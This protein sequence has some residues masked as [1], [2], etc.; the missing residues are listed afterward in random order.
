MTENLTQQHGLVREITNRGWFANP[1]GKQGYEVILLKR[2][3]NGGTRFYHS[4]K[5]GQ[6]LRIVERLLSSYIALEVDMRHARAFTVS[7]SFNTRHSGRNVTLELNVRYHV[8]DA[9][10]V[11]METVDPLGELRDKVISALNR[12]L[13]TYSERDINLA[14]IDK[15]VMNIGQVPHLGLV[16]EDLDVVKFEKDSSE[17][18]REQKYITELQDAEHSIHLARLIGSSN[19]SPLIISKLLALPTKD[20]FREIGALMEKAS[21]PALNKIFSEDYGE[22]QIKVTSPTSIH[23]GIPA[24]SL[25]TIETYI[26][27]INLLLSIDVIYI[28]LATLKLGD[29]SLVKEFLS[30]IKGLNVRKLSDMPLQFLEESKISTLQ[31]FSVHYGSPVSVDILGVGTVLET[32]RDTIK[33][34]VWRGK[35]EKAIADIEKEK[36]KIDTDTKRLEV[37]LKRK[38]LEKVTIENQRLALEV[39]NQ[40]ID[41][42]IKARDFELNTVE[43]D[44]LINMI[45]PHLGLVAQGLNASIEASVNY[46]TKQLTKK[47]RK[48]NSGLKHEEDTEED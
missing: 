4:L 36:A 28:V 35:H 46:K 1:A 32:L 8:S 43:K 39:A 34:L 18:E 48:P 42:I 17:E 16:I 41:L 45:Y 19:I 6:T 15:I 38:E 7:G 37:E 23:L 21:P 33:D 20:A 29:E 13:I 10:I 12:E 3:G 44:L 5:P 22:F 11:A 40:K 24:A 30:R 25:I 31:L 47:K 26:D 27:L 9:R 2:V 14:L